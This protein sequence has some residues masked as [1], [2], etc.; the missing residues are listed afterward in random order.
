[1]RT[2]PTVLPSSSPPRPRRQDVMVY[3]NI[4]CQGETPS[5]PWTSVRIGEL[6]GVVFDLGDGKTADRAT[7]GSDRGVDL[8]LRVAL[9]LGLQFGQELRVIQFHIFEMSGVER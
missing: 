9:Q 4:F 5:S 8:G 6:R 2:W 7:G 3:H 1:M